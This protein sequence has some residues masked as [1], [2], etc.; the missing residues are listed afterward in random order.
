MEQRFVHLTAQSSQL[1]IVGRRSADSLVG[2][3]RSPQWNKY[4]SC[5][6]VR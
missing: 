4:E 2:A 5:A 1:R 3:L 6:K